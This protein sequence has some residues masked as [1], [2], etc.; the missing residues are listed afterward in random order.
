MDR[1]TQDSE[2]SAAKAGAGCNTCHMWERA[3]LARCG[4]GLQ[5]MP[6]V[7]V[8]C[9]TCQGCSTC[10]VWAAGDGHPPP[11]LDPPWYWW[12]AMTPSDGGK[13]S[14]VA[15]RC[16]CITGFPC[17]LRCFAACVDPPP[18]MLCPRHA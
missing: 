6:D 12:S 8:G 18:V 15:L 11:H 10:Q 17:L 16:R 4:S 9:N 7:G 1:N 5:Y 13:R 2:G 3:A 14:G